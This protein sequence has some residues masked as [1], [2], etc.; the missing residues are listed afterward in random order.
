MPNT[1]ARSWK[2]AEYSCS[3]GKK[4]SKVMPMLN[5]CF[6]PGWLDGMR[7]KRL[8]RGYAISRHVMS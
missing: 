8:P 4:K 6:R 1:L 7:M 5:R 3:T 2:N